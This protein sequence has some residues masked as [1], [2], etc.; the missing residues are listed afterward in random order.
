MAL[1]LVVKLRVPI[2][3]SSIVPTAAL[4]F[5]KWLPLKR[6][7]AL[8]RRD[9]G[10]TAYIWFDITTTWWG[11]QMKEEDLPKHINVCAHFVNIDVV[12]TGVADE[13]AAYIRD[14]DYKELPAPQNKALQDR[15]DELGK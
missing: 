14:R 3:V 12:I 6:D 5:S 7:E 2:A 10:L 13:L 9:D 11:H 4:I 15:F 1:E 8:Q